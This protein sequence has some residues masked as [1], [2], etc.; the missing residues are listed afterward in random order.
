MSPRRRDAWT[1]RLAMLGG[2]L[3]GLALLYAIRPVT[4]ERTPVRTVEARPVEAAPAPQLRPAPRPPQAPALA[5]SAEP[6]EE[7]EA[8]V[9]PIDTGEMDWDL[10]RIEVR[11]EDADGYVVDDAWGGLTGCSVESFERLED[12]FVATVVAGDLCEAMAYRRD[13]LLSVRSDYLEFEAVDGLV[14]TLVFP[15]E[16]TGGI[17]VQFQPAEGGMLVVGVMP[18]TPASLA[19]LAPGDL[20][21]AVEG[22][23]VSGLDA[24]DFVDEMTGP[25]GSDVEFEVEFEADTGLTRSSVVLTR[26][27]LSG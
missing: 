8:L 13:G 2:L 16:R 12:G 7:D 27:F 24:Q 22:L 19:G 9:E 21:V 11:Y 20:I 14:A 6:Q 4:P 5:P 3:L 18:G 10:A 25:E 23:D 15:A 17:G 26:A 1:T